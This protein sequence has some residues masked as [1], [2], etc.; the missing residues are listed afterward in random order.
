MS[1]LGARKKTDTNRRSRPSKRIASEIRKLTCGQVMLAAHEVDEMDSIAPVRGIGGES[2]VTERVVSQL[3]TELDG[4]QSLQ[5]VVVIGATN[6]ADMLD[7]ALL[8][9]GRIDK[10]IFVALPDKEARQKILE[11]HVTDK[12]IAKDIDVIT[13]EA[14]I[15]ED[16]PVGYVT[17][18]GFA[19]YVKKSIA[20]G[21]L[22]TKLSNK[23]TKLEIEINGQNYSAIVID[24][25]LYDPSGTK[26]RL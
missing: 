21:Y 5:G 22:P 1:L 9:P 16:K 20:F 2:M 3:L 12:P 6:R 15:K 18:G 26:M 17:S 13:D 24:K 25:P 4:I 7:T 8:R 23:N 11:I 10:L 19:H 14:I